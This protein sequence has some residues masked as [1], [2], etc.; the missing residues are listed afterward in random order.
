MAYV[1]VPAQDGGTV[2]VDAGSSCEC[3]PSQTSVCQPLMTSCSSDAHCPEYFTCVVPPVPTCAPNPSPNAGIS[4]CQ[5][6]AMDLI[7]APS[8]TCQP[9]YKG[10]T[11]STGSSGGTPTTNAP[12]ASDPGAGGHTAS[13]PPTA[14]GHQNSADAG[15]DDGGGSVPVDQPRCSV[16][17]VGSGHAQTSGFVTFGVL[18]FALRLRRQRKRG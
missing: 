15:A 2:A 12:E 6:M 14:S 8:G 7:A 16:G 13:N 1:D 11:V 3:H 9:M 17:A 5:Q 4:A 18:M 10:S